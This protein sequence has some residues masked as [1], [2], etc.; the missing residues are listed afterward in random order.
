MQFQRINPEVERFIEEQV[1]AGRFESR[2]AVV[3]AAV[4]RMMHEPPEA[5]A[6]DDEDIKAIDEADRQIDRG[7]FIEFPEFAAKMREKFCK[8]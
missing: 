2:E 7:E 6:L 1:Q 8:P 5:L 4:E 3:E